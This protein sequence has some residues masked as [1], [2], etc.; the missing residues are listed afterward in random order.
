M[1]SVK[2]VLYRPDKAAAKVYAEL[3]R[4]YLLLHDAFGTST[5]N[6]PLYRVMK[7]LIALRSRV[8]RETQ[9]AKHK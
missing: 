2:D 1:T 4:L 9:D 3:Y 5:G 7:D 6:E 8:R